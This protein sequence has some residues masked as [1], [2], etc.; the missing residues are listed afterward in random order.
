MLDHVAARQ[1]QALEQPVAK[2]RDAEQQRRNAERR[3]GEVEA[4]RNQLEQIER[5]RGERDDRRRREQDAA[6]P[7]V[8]RHHPARGPQVEQ[9][10]AQH[11]DI[12]P[13]HVDP[14]DRSA[15]DA[16][17]RLQGL[18]GDLADHQ[19]M[20]LVR[21]QSEVAED[22]WNAQRH[23][24]PAPF[25]PR[26]GP[27]IDHGHEE[28]QG[29]R[30]EDTQEDQAQRG[31]EPHRRG[32]GEAEDDPRG[33]DDERHQ[34]R[35]EQPVELRLLAAQR[36]IAGH[37]RGGG[38]TQC[39]ERDGRVHLSRI[40]GARGGFEPPGGAGRTTPSPGKPRD[41]RPE[42]PLFSPRLVARARIFS[43]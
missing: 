16:A 22:R 30:G 31:L 24:D 25:Q 34:E 10:P 33:P 42:S 23:P 14:E 40:G 15:P 21:E 11:Q 3:G 29:R 1:R 17:T 9:R 39:S 18:E 27:G 41:A 36:H 35:N 7:L 19:V 4:Q 6:P 26:P 20:R 38:E 43:L 37:R 28:P 2:H 12:G 32:D 8:G 5:A 13:G